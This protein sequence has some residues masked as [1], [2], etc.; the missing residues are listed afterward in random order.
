[1]RKILI[2]LLLLA[3]AT[4]VWIYLRRSAPPELPFAKV[5]RERLVSTLVTNGKT[6]PVEWVAVRS[7]RA[8]LI[9]KVLVTKGQRIGAGGPMVELEARQLRADL[10]SAEARVAQAR[11]ELEVL[12]RGGRASE[13]ADIQGS[14]ARARLDL[15]EAG[16]DLE[17]LR[18][19]QKKEAATGVEV[20]EA[21]RRL[22]RAQTEMRALEE[23]RAAL[24]TSTDRSAAQA[25]LREAEAAAALARR[26]IE[27]SVIRAPLSGSV[28][29]L[30]ARPGAWLNPGDLVAKIGRLDQLQVL[31]YVDEPELGRV[32]KGMPVA[33]TWDAL[34]G[35]EWSGRV[36]R[37]PTEIV[38][39]GTRQVGEV[40]C[41][42]ANPDGQLPPGANINATIQSRVV[43]GA[44]AVP[45]EALRRENNQ[46]GVF[47]LEGGRLA[48]RPVQTGVSSVTRV[49]ALSGLAEGDLVVLATEAALK[50]GMEARVRRAG[51]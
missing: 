23:R 32:A 51:E 15:A 1:M 42:I 45:R 19:L 46:S 12:E 22:A 25:R 34:P 13:L 11:A 37:I 17:A 16:R 10:A 18:R 44:L 9:A 39:L 14:L 7:E 28:Y 38:S 4:A 8:G 27:L 30:A 43:E 33:L 20:A 36:E 21:E 49:Q 5:G 24:V 40:L 31:V 2:P 3:G 6:E 35:R 47:V 26:N 48:W 29:D 50:A 41:Q